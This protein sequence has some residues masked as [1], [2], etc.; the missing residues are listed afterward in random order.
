MN[1]PQPNT[2]L[3][4]FFLRENLT[5]IFPYFYLFFYFPRSHRPPPFLPPTP[6][7]AV[8]SPNRTLIANLTATF[9]A[10]DGLSWGQAGA[11]WLVFFFK[12]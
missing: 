1:A 11:L 2:P 7:G 12:N 10:Q 9:V 3:F 8:P 5:F 4:L 6:M